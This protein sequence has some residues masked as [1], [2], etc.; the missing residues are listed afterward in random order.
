VIYT[1]S[2]FEKKG[3]QPLYYWS[4]DGQTQL[5]KKYLT[6]FNVV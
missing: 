1:F 6:L 4:V 3:T 5:L 2:V